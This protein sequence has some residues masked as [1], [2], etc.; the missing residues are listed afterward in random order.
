MAAHVVILG[1]GTGGTLAANRLRKAL[2]HRESAITVVDQDDRHVYQPGLLFVPFGLAH[3]EDI[4]R[5]AAAPAARRASTSVA[6]RRST[7]STSTTNDGAPRRR[8]DP[9]A[10]TCSSSPPAPTLVPEETEGLT[11]RVGWRRSSPSTP[12]G[13][14]GARGGA[15]DLRRGPARRER[16]RHADQVPGRAARVLLP[17]R[18]VLP[19]ARHPRPGRSSPT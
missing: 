3:V 8:H 13:R 6:V 5:P 14:G 19:R 1:G 16:G 7:V 9:P 2:R 11:G 12:R 4:V 18:L 15:G 17:G 10:T